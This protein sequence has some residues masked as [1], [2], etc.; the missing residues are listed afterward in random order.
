MDNI[1]R[2]IHHPAGKAGL[3]I[4]LAIG[5]AAALIGETSKALVFVGFCRF[6]ADH[7]G[8]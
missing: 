3:I 7:F 4:G 8:R 2:L 5:A 6:I 1:S